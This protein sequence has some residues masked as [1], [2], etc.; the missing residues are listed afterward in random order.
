[1]TKNIM[2]NCLGCIFYAYITLAAQHLHEKE[3]K[4]KEICKW[5]SY[6]PA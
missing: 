4:I 6:S 2:C 5:L 1:M 3:Q